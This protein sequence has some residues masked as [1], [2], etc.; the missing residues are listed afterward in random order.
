[1]YVTLLRCHLRLEPFRPL[2]IWPSS[3]KGSSSPMRRVLRTFRS[4]G[5]FFNE[6]GLLCYLWDIHERPNGATW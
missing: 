1:M 5:P 4:L 6:D 3:L 2:E